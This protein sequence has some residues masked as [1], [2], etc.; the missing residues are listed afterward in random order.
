MGHERLIAQAA[1][2]FS[3]P[4]VPENRDESAAAACALARMLPD[5]HPSSIRSSDH[6]RVQRWARDALAVQRGV[7]T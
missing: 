4:Q 6:G 1:R 3:L 7:R 2:V 5:V